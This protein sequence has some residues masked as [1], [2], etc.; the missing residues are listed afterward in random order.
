MNILELIAEL[1][2]IAVNNPDIS[3]YGDFQDENLEYYVYYVEDSDNKPYVW[4]H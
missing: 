4:I 2:K 3:V 1:A